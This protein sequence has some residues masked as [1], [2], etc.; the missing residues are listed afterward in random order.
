MHSFN[1]CLVHCVWGTKERRRFIDEKLKARLWPYL[2]GIARENKMR[3]LIIGGVADHVHVLLS[4]P[5]TLSVGK[6]IQLLKGNS[7]KWVHETFRE[8]WDFQWQ[9]GYGA[10]SIGISGVENTTRYIQRQEE[11]HR[12]LTFME[13]LEGFLK[14]HGMEYVA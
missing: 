9:E 10:F 3:A 4:L 5:P 1:S 14:R 8:Q 7:F 2:G 11:H 12:K 6:S 13:E